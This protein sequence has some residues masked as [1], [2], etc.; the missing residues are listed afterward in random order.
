MGKGR[1]GGREG[2]KMIGITL[3]MEMMGKKVEGIND[4]YNCCSTDNFSVNI[5]YVTTSV[6]ALQTRRKD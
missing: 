6:I 3:Y 2:K 1:E 4:A 5:K